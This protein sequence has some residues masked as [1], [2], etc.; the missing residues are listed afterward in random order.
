MLYDVFIS[1]AH[2]DKEELVRPLAE[3]LQQSRIEV[4]Y[5][6]FSLLAGDSLRRSIDKGLSKSRYGIVV[7]SPHFIAKEWPQ[8]EL[9][10][11]VQRQ[12][13]EK[14]N[15]I[16]PV[17]HNVSLEDVL[18]FSPPLADKV[19]ISSAGG[20]DHVVSELLKAI[21]PEGSTLLIARDL[22]LA[23]GHDPPVVTDDWWLEV[24]E[25]SGSNPVE[26][27]FQDAICWGHWGFPLPDRSNLPAERGERLAFAAA[28]MLWQEKA[29]E[30]RVSQVTR[31]MDVLQFIDS[32][33]GLRDVCHSHPGYLASYAPQLTI[34]GYGGPFEDMFEEWYRAS[35]ASHQ[36]R[37]D[38]GDTI[39]SPLTTTGLAPA[40]EELVA[41]RHPELGEY[42]PEF[43]ACDFV[44]GDMFGPSVLVHDTIDYLVWLLSDES[45]WLPTHIRQCLLIGMKEWNQWLWWSKS[46]R[47]GFQT[48]SDT[49]KLASQLFRAAKNECPASQVNLTERSMRDI[50]TR[51]Q[52]TI[53]ILGLPETA[54]TLCDRFLCAGFVGHWLAKD[55]HRRERQQGQQT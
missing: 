48:N 4:W 38:S 34:P 21:R 37:R 15:V 49:G 46:S 31:P 7:I 19:A 16:I 26:G 45:S 8:W 43:I 18:A 20:L 2:E 27:T 3:R 9:D 28:Q 13:A 50:G 52:H 53:D 30:L 22:L 55:A 32:C 40:C 12:M 33:P 5:D 51:F 10:G 23:M 39:G 1:H 54:S 11:L 36:Q 25:F 47:S 24:V 44:Q 6:E 41:L 17:W 14:R 29:S 35:V 42:R